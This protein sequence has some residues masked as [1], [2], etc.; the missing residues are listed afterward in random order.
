MR[1][2]NNKIIS[3][4]KVLFE[5]TPENYIIKMVLQNKLKCSNI[6][7]DRTNDT[8]FVYWEKE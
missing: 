7:V 8:L 5:Y 4:R 2:V 6:E 1:I 3:N